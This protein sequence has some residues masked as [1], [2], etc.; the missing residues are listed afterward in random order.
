MNVFNHLVHEK[1]IVVWHDYAWQPGDV[2]YETLA[3]ILA[4]IPTVCKDKLYAVRN[5]MCAVYFPFQTKNYPPSVVSRK[6]EAFT[7]KLS[8]IK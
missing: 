7:I 8:K 1:S 4:G 2:R 5:T 6:E 3:A